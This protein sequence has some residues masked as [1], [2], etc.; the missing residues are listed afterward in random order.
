M[1][2]LSPTTAKDIHWNSSLLQPPSDSRGKGRLLSDVSG[3]YLSNGFWRDNWTW[4]QLDF[5]P[6]CWSYH[7]TDG[8]C[9]YVCVSGPEN[10][11]AMELDMRMRLAELQLKYREK[12]RELARL[13]RRS[14]S[15]WVF[16]C[17]TGCCVKDRAF[18]LCFCLQRQGNGSWICIVLT[19]EALRYYWRYMINHPVALWYEYR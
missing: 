7:V 15:E 8:A 18:L 6:R 12:Q 3:S 13:Q 1:S 9:V 10:M 11:D 4:A 17:Y 14:S 19:S 16:D 5:G 2:F